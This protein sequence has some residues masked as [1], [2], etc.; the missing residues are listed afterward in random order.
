MS[1]A[2][3]IRTRLAEEHG[4]EVPF[5]AELVRTY[6]GYW[7]R[8]EGAWSWSLWHPADRV[9][10]GSQYPATELLRCPAWQVD[11][12]DRAPD[13]SIYP[14]DDCQRHGITSHSHPDRRG[15]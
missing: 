9:T 1:A 8:K 5:D 6:A 15:H 3:R 2:H 10:F 4:I 7:Q 13:R 14:C 11:P 12:A